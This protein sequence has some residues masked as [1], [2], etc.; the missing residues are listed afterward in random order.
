MKIKRLI[1]VIFMGF[2]LSYCYT[3]QKVVSQTNEVSLSE[4]IQLTPAHIQLLN[5]LGLRIVVPNYI[6]LGFQLEKVEAELER[7]TRVGGIS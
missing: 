1:N 3:N 7:S 5:S 2:L 6:P 4:E